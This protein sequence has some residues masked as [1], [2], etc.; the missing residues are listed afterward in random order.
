MSDKLKYELLDFAARLCAVLPPLISTLCYFPVWIEQSPGATFSGMTLVIVFVCMIPFWRKIVG[1]AKNFTSTAMPVFWLVIF[2]IFMV[3][4]EIVDKFIF[5]SL[6]GLAGSLLSMG[7]CIFRNKFAPKKEKTSDTSEDD[8]EDN[9]ED[10][11]VND[12]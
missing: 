5:I 2:A 4:K 7:V 11:D 8:E 1:F 10:G 6:F 3:L 12:E 9:N